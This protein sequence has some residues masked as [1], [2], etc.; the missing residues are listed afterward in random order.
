TIGSWSS[1]YY[2]NLAVPKPRR[3]SAGSVTI[4]TIPKARSRF[5]PP[6]PRS[7]QLPWGTIG[8]FNLTES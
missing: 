1:H 6:T 4:Y 2:G 8:I 5:L 3:F 7:L